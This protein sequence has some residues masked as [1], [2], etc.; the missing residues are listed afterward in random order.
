LG[1]ASILTVTSLATRTSPVLRGKWILSNMLGTPPPEPPPNVPPLAENKAGGK[2]L[3]VRERLEA[4]RANPTCAAC[5]KVMDPLGF[6]L[7][8]FDAIG[9]W[10][11]VDAGLPIDSKATLATG[12][13]VN[14]AVDLRNQLLLA[15][16]EQFVKTFTSKLMTFGLG[17]GLDYNDAPVV[18]S[19]ARTA[20]KDDY[21]F[22]SLVMGIV[23]SPPFQMRTKRNAEVVAEA[24]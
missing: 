16:P 8:N 17:R 9:Q 6:A 12:Q 23:N 11:N 10:R 18:R 14:G 15:Q 1:H 22:S 2:A 7:E 24:R 3:S 13:Q 19:I 4:H 20:A 21:K 5:H